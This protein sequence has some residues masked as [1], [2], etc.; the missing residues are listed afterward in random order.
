MTLRRPLHGPAT[1]LATRLCRLV[2]TS[3]E[4]VVQR[5]LLFEDRLGEWADGDELHPA[6]ARP[7][8]GVQ[9]QEARDAL[10]PQ[11]IV[12]LGMIDDHQLAIGCS[13]ERLLGDVLSVALDEKRVPQ[14]LLLVT[15]VHGED[16]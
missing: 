7:L 9:G 11:R 8:D 3:G 1:R 16:A 6:L 15:D 14:A 10:P 4:H 12:Y 2:A 13:G 5:R